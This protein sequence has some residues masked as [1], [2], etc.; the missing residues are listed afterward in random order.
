MGYTHIHIHS[1][2]KSKQSNKNKVQQIDPAKKENEKLYL[3]VKN[4]TS[5]LGVHWKD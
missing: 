5:V 2:A 1:L 3:A 4:K